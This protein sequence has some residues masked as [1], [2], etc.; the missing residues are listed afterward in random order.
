MVL[1]TNDLDAVLLLELL[2]ARQHV[3]A[4]HSADIERAIIN[5]QAHLVDTFA[6]VKTRP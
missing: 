5:L 2:I 1:A 3:R 4:T 6:S